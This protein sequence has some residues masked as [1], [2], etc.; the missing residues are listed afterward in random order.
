MIREAN[1]APCKTC[2]DR[3]SGCHSKCLSYKV[4][5]ENWNKSKE[6]IDGEANRER[7]LN[8]FTVDGYRRVAKL[9][10]RR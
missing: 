6:A 7:M 3:Y 5:K 10:R 9:M 4:W 1:S 8:N 2:E